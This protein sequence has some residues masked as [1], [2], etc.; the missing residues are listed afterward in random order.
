MV[1]VRVSSSTPDGTTITV[2]A[3]TT[4]KLHSVSAGKL[5]LV[6]S[7]SAAPR[8]TIEQTVARSEGLTYFHQGRQIYFYDA[9]FSYV[10]TNRGDAS[11][12]GPI[13]IEIR[14]MLPDD[15]SVDVPQSL[16]D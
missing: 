3:T 15:A 10:V 7:K 5:L 14:F 6:R 13:R 16:P 1:R 11:T 2:T 8:L 9:D 12:E 4:S